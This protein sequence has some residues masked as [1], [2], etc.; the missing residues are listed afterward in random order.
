MDKKY[1]DFDDARLRD[2]KARHC[3]YRFC[4]RCAR[5]LAA[6]TIDGVSRLACPDSACGFVFYQNPIPAAGGIVVED[7]RV[8]LVRRAHPPMVDWW[9]FPAGFMEWGEHP[10]QTAVREV[11][12]ETGLIVRLTGFFE[13]YSGTDDPRVN[14]V[15]LL[16]LAERIGGA[17]R[18]ADDAA[19]AR[20][21]SF[22]DLPDRIAFESHRQAL[23]DYD[24]R[25]RRR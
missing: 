14:A 18:P 6:A 13:V 3:G 5:P 23:A 17:L 4:P 2:L 9:C 12:E 16:Y 15:L 10:A 24:R 22:D 21:F 20:F 19:E 1:H 7:D 8:L 11:A 25:V